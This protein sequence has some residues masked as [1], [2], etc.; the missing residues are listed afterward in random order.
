MTIRA[1]VNPQKQ[2]QVTRFSVSAQNIDIKELKGVDV[3]DL[4]DGSV[5]VY[6]QTSGDFVATKTLSKQ[7]INGGNF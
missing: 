4:Q 3:T 1:K 5:L 7:I 2:L 6:E